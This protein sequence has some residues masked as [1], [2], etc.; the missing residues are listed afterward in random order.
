MQALQFANDAHVGQKI[1]NQ[2]VPPQP[3]EEPGLIHF[4]KGSKRTAGPPQSGPHADGAPEAAALGAIKPATRSATV[5]C[6]GTCSLDAEREAAMAPEAGA[7]AEAEAEEELGG[8]RPGTEAGA[9]PK[10]AEAE[11]GT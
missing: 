6:Y 10:A 7:M 9:G 11:V 2:A 3:K 8:A 5:P 4:G 1:L